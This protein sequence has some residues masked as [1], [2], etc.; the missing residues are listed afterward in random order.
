MQHY[1]QMDLSLFVGII[2]LIGSLLWVGVGH[3]M[4][5]SPY[6]GWRVRALIFLL[7]IGGAW[8]GL[9]NI[10]HNHTL[11]LGVCLLM[12]AFSLLPAWVIWFHTRQLKRAKSKERHN[13]KDPIL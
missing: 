9:A 2:Q 7:V 13:E 3:M 1:A 6:T 5:R 11:Y 12:T 8:A 4:N 10:T